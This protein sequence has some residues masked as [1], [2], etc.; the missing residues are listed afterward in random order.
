MDAIAT[1]AAKAKGS[2][3]KA[4]SANGNASP[5]PAAANTSRPQTKPSPAATQAAQSSGGWFSRLMRRFTS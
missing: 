1:H 2:Y 3:M 4:A 5:K